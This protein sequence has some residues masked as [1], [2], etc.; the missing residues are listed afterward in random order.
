M[1]I[2]RGDIFMARLSA[3]EDGGSIQEGRRPILIIS[4]DLANKHSPVVTIVPITS[5]LRKKQLPTHVLI[6]GCGT[7]KKSIVLAGQIMSLNKSRLGKRMGSIKETV[8]ESQVDKAIK[9]QLN[10]Q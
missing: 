6:E 10:V 8:Y 7:V 5:K 3:D 2:S 4:N 1:M 9:I